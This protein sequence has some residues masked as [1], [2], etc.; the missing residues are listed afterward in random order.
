MATVMTSIVPSAKT[1]SD[2]L[3]LGLT[4]EYGMEQLES[5]KICK[6]SVMCENRECSKSTLK[7]LS[8]K[9]WWIYH[10]QSVT[11]RMRKGD[12]ITKKY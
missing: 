5:E 11:N 1:M 6:T 12:N 9:A 8:R 4:H 7:F 3:P 2:T 10:L